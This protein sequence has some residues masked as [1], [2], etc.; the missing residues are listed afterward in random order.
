MSAPQNVPP[1]LREQLQK[2]SGHPNDT[3]K[4][5]EFWHARTCFVSSGDAFLKY[6]FRSLIPYRAPTAILIFYVPSRDH[7][8]W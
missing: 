7:F 2:L 8:M 3:S 4:I 1:W 6:C 5:T